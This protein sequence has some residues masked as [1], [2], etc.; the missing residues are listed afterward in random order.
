MGNIWGA[1]KDT[2]TAPFVGEL[3]LTHLFLLIGAILVFIAIWVLIL[4][5][6][7][8]AAAEI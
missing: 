3:D 5:H 1:I 4:N 6:I 2:L 8:I 7:A